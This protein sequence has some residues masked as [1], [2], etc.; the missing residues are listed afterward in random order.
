MTSK[1]ISTIDSNLITVVCNAE[2]KH[3][4]NRRLLVEI[5]T[6]FGLNLEEHTSSILA[7]L[8]NQL[9]LEIQTEAT[10][11]VPLSIHSCS[12]THSC[13]CHHN[14]FHFLFTF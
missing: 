6:E 4:T 9:V 8:V 1:W 7:I 10:T 2:T 12:Y 5:I 14:L 11:D 3:D 13:K